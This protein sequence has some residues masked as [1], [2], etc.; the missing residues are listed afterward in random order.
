[1]SPRSLEQNHVPLEGNLASTQSTYLITWT[2]NLNLEFTEYVATDGLA[3]PEQ[4][5]RTSRW[6]K[7]KVTAQTRK[8]WATDGL[9]VTTICQAVLRNGES[10]KKTFWLYYGKRLVTAVRCAVDATEYEIIQH[11]LNNH[12]KCPCVSSY[13]P[14]YSP[15]TIRGMICHSSIRQYE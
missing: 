3:Q 4:S 13:F 14:M 2:T 15:S 7:H 10:M 6:P 12:D 8:Q 9:T 1:M 11:A 5:S